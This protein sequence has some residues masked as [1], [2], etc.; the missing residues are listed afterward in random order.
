MIRCTR[1]RQNEPRRLS[2]GTSK[3]NGIPEKGRKG[4]KAWTARCASS[5]NPAMCQRDEEM[6]MRRQMRVRSVRACGRDAKSPDCDT[7]AHASAAYSEHP[8]HH[9]SKNERA[10]PSDG[11]ASPNLISTSETRTDA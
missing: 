8:S 10:G 7:G 1:A 4:A 5:S 6:P 11:S 3:M 9:D 2:R